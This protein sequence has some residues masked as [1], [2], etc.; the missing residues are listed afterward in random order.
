M[1]LWVEKLLLLCC[2]SYD[3]A[4]MGITAIA[5]QQCLNGQGEKE[6]KQLLI[7]EPNK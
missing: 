7:F 5:A 6:I 2:G 3:N 1:Q 4:L